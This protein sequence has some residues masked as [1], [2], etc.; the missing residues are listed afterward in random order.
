MD[1]LVICGG[2]YA[3]ATTCLSFS[4]GQWIISHI[5]AEGR[6]AHS[7]W[8]TEQGLVLMGGYDSPISS[9]VVPRAGEQGGPGFAMQ[10]DTRYRIE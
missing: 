4:S 6:D 10:Y 1:S 3:S 5:L 2:Y 8:Q 7:S 9:E